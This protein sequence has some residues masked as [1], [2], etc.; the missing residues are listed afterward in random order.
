MSNKSSGTAFEKEFAK[1]LSQHGF[2]ARLD[3]GGKSGQTTDILAS[4]NGTSYMFECKVCARD[5]FN[6]E[7]VELNQSMSMEHF[8]RCG[9]SETW[10]V[11]KVAENIYLNKTAITRPSE[12]IPLEGWLRNDSNNI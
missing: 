1:L 3:A 6:I 7:R 8:R 4:R 10:F 11:F 5:Y 9:N 2:W 12:G